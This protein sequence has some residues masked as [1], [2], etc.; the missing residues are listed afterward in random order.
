MAIV[1]VTPDVVATM[2][3]SRATSAWR[4]QPATAR[5]SSRHGE[6]GA[7][8]RRSQWGALWQV[9]LPP[10]EHLAS[11]KLDNPSY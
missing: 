4:P 1:K 8:A 11:C 9:G 7:D 3:C 6:L 2:S 10:C 5:G